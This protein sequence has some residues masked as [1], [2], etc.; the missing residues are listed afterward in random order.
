LLR[1]HLLRGKLLL[2]PLLELDLARTL[3][4]S[5]CPSQIAGLPLGL[6]LLARW[7]RRPNLNLRRGLAEYLAL[8]RA[9]GRTLDEALRL[10]PE[11]PFPPKGQRINAR[12]T[13]RHA[14]WLPMPPQELA[15]PSS[16]RDL[17]CCE[18]WLFA[19]E[20]FCLGSG[21]SRSRPSAELL[22]E[23]HG[24]LEGPPLLVHPLIHLADEVEERGLGG[25]CIQ[26]C[27]ERVLRAATFGYR[28]L[29]RLEGTL[30]G[31]NRYDARGRLPAE[32]VQERLDYL[33]LLGAQS[34]E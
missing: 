20:D 22:A 4:R 14:V 9:L 28:L 16:C 12:L 10:A 32:P 27:E 18:S 11:H 15:P 24:L 7:Q 19:S 3:A 5:L 29:H 8:N 34:R 31:R 30:D 13:P 33:A 1:R 2:H 26:G 23:L 17:L 6:G 21:E 25:S